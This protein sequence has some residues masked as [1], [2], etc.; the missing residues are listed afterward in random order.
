MN[1]HEELCDAISLA[2]L[3]GN[4]I[5]GLQLLQILRLDILAVIDNYHSFKRNTNVIGGDNNNFSID[6]DDI[7]KDKIYLKYLN[8]ISKA[9]K[10]I[11]KLSDSMP[12]TSGV[13]DIQK[14]KDI[15]KKMELDALSCITKLYQG[16]ELPTELIQA[17]TKLFNDTNAKLNAVYTYI[18][19]RNRENNTD[20]LERYLKSLIENKPWP[21]NSFSRLLKKKLREMRK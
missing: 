1:K 19:K 2:F 7:E 16:K 18:K 13:R 14:K 12:M 15:V 8:N 11:I 5:I 3:G 21:K 10:D 20:I 6:T 17:Q 4:R 9:Q